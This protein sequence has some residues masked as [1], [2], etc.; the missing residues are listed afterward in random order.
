MWGSRC[1][2][3]GDLNADP[4]INPCL[5]KGIATGRF[6]DLALAHSVGSGKEPDATCKF[7]LNGKVGTRRDFM[8]ASSPCFGCFG[9]MPGH[10]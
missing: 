6:I 4:G 10:G 9:R 1:L 8:I 3:L 5:V 7:K 2:L